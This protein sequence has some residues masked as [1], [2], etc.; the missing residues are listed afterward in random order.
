M[1]SQHSYEASRLSCQ[2]KHT[3]IIQ[4]VRNISCLIIAL[5]QVNGRR[6]A[7]FRHSSRKPRGAMQWIRL[8]FPWS[9]D[10][11]APGTLYRRVESVFIGK[12]SQG[13]P[14]NSSIG[15]REVRNRND[16]PQ[17][18]IMIRAAVYKCPFC[19]SGRLAREDLGDKSYKLIL[20]KMEKFGRRRQ[21]F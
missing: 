8:K 16:K 4:R 6:R 11:V 21:F 1:K 5:L 7:S 20:Y 12:H 13:S 19:N 10:Y 17:D 2:T 3:V 18:R 15:P 9:L 14:P